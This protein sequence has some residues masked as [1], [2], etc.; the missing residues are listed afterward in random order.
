M[1]TLVFTGCDILNFGDRGG[2]SESESENNESNSVEEESE[3]KL[4]ESPATDFEYKVLSDGTI[5]V[6]YIGNNAYVVV[7]EKIEN[8][9]VTVIAAD[10][11]EKAKPFLK[12]VILP[13]TIKT[14]ELRAFKDCILLESVNIPSSVSKI[15]AI[16]FKNCVALERIEIYSNCLDVNSEAAFQASG[17]KTV[18][19]GEGVSYIPTWCFA[20]T[21]LSEIVIPST[22]TEIGYSAFAGCALER[23]TLNEGLTTIGH[24]AFVSNIQLQEITI[25]KTVTSV[26]EMAFSGCSS[27]EKVIF[28]G[29]APATYE[30]SDSITGKWDPINT[31]YTVYYHQGAQGFTSP[32]WYGYT[33]EILGK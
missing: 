21:P 20:E 2:E 11:F 22:V 3:S 4:E 13:K 28:K 23:I 8:K 7:P 25:P 16:A 19:L 18:I 17:I 12:A 27:L 29:N 33:T 26:T 32:E 14:V 6:S 1:L 30:Y 10:G 24:K 31:N 15:G 9:D 5:E